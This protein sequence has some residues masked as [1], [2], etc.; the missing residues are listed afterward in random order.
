MAAL[1][2]YWGACEILLRSLILT[3]NLTALRLRVPVDLDVK[4]LTIVRLRLLPWVA[5]TSMTDG[6]ANVHELLFSSIS[7]SEQTTYC[8][9]WW[10]GEIDV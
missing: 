4:Y 3:T 10:S 1:K 6:T 9:V 8:R 2:C 7:L 5:A